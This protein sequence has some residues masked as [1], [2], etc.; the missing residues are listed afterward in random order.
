MRGETQKVYGQV[1]PSLTATE[2]EM[3]DNVF[4]AWVPAL[5]FNAAAFRFSTGE[6][7]V[8]V[9]LSAILMHAVDVHFYRA[10][11]YLDRIRPILKG[12]K[13]KEMQPFSGIAEELL[14]IRTA[15]RYVGGDLSSWSELPPGEFY[16]SHD[17]H[18]SSI[19]GVQFFFIVLH[20]LGHVCLGHL[21]QGNLKPVL[22]DYHTGGLSYYQLGHEREHAADRFALNI[23][24]TRSTDCAIPL[25][26]L[27]AF[28]RYVEERRPYFAAKEPHDPGM[29][30]RI[31]APQLIVSHPR[32]SERVRRLKSEGLDTGW[33]SH[34]W[35]LLDTRINQTDN[36]GTA[37]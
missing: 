8:A 18:V 35:N 9:S 16:T 3:A 24:Q 26:S 28:L 21:S 13:P 1:A 37:A 33:Y 19:F 14:H 4:F 23:M 11:G 2:R 12:E 29:E 10:L 27:F 17:E 34:F 32:A 30:V 31:P 25:G 20:E 36:G 15:A 7:T 6:I 22:S 5:G